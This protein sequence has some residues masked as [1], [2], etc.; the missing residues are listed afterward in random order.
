MHFARA[1]IL[2]LMIALAP[3]LTESSVGELAGSRSAIPTWTA[4]H[5]VHSA[6]LQPVPTIPPAERD[7]ETTPLSRLDAGASGS[8][9]VMAKRRSK[10][11]PES[12]VYPSGS[13]C[14][15]DFFTPI[16]C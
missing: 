3:R 6:A 14:R 7:G 16:R 1:L 10:G 12:D 4:S 9:S 5:G 2:V 8:V 15:D 11:R 13:D